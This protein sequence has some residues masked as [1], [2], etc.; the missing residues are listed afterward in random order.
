MRELWHDVSTHPFAA[1]CFL[2]YWLAVWTAYWTLNWS[3]GI[4]TVG[5]ILGLLAPAIAG[6]LVGWS[7]APKREG[8]LLGGRRLAG[9]PLA[10]A[11]IIFV[12]VTIIFVPAFARA[13]QHAPRELPGAVV[14]WLGASA[15]MALLVLPLGWLGAFSGGVIANVVRARGVR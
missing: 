3:S 9:G 6:S 15:L 11:V 8:L 12:D 2:V 1:A 5:V 10:A 7:R 13:L 4:P 14:A